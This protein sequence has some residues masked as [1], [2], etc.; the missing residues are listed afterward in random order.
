M[1]PAGVYVKIGA[2]AKPK[3]ISAT[4]MLDDDEEENK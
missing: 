4:G 3:G 1:N 2:E